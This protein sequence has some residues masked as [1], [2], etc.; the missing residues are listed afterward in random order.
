MVLSAAER[1]AIAQELNEL[2]RDVQRILDATQVRITHLAA[3]IEE[4]RA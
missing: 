1:L 3:V 2:G 4:P